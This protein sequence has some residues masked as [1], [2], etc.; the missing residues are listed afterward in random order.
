MSPNAT[1]ISFYSQEIIDAV[2]SA[3]GNWRAAVVAVI[4]EIV[5]S[6]ECFSSGEVVRILRITDPALAFKVL[7]VGEYVRDAFY[8][9]QMPPYDT[10]N[11]GQQFPLQVGRTTEGLYPT[12]TPVG[13][14]V[15]VYGPSQAACEAHEFE[16][17]VP[18]PSEDLDQVAHTDSN[19]A[20]P[21]VLDGDDDDDDGTVSTPSTL[22]TPSTSPTPSNGGSGVTLKGRKATKSLTATVTAEC[23][24]YVSRSAFEHFVHLRGTGMRGGDPVF[25]RV[26]ND[27]VIIGL[28]DMPGATKLTL[29]A[30]R[31]RVKVPNSTG[32]PFHSGDRY[33]VE[34]SSIAITV[35]LSTTI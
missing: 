35:D 10:D 26:D 31:G 22:S 29:E 18:V 21:A 3:Q 28:D 14:L 34:V 23:R 8:A 9:G 25:V 13:Q 16:V 24:L 30:T 19:P 5:Q 12:R 7:S 20:I 33:S 2:T 11:D 4:N 17:Y 32:A 27:E 6:G 15:F 1:P